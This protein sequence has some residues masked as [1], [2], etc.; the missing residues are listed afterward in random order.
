M[1][2]IFTNALS[3]NP[4]IESEDIKKSDFVIVANNIIF[5]E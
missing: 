4:I 5:N 2:P 3:T 1:E